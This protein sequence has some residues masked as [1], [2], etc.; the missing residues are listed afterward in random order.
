MSV[1]MKFAFADPP[2]LGCA[3]FYAAQHPEAMIWD[4]PE[5]HR[6][7]IERLCDEYPDGWAMSLNVPSLRVI[8]PMCPL[9]AR[10]LSWVKPFASFKKGVHRAYAW[11]PIIAMGGR[12]IPSYKNTIRDWIAVPAALQKG[13]VGAKPAKVCH[14]ILDWLNFQPGDTLDDLFP[15]TG[16][17]GEVVAVRSGE[18]CQLGMFAEVAAE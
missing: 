15:G 12:S 6:Q 9:E 7:L 5:T 11:E 14:F 17:M 10:V 8:L 1:S 2:Y 13:L 3:R 4:D 16:I 18:P